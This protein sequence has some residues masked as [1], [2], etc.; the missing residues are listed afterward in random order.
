MRKLAPLT[1]TLILFL[2]GFAAAAPGDT[3]ATIATCLGRFSAEVEHATLLGQDRAEIAAGR[4][5]FLELYETV[6]SRALL[7]LRIRA[8]TEQARLLELAWFGTNARHADLALRKANA[9]I[10]TCTGLLLVQPEAGP[11]PQ[12]RMGL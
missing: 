1:V 7:A 3:G 2:N 8:K 6:G 4:E 5:V 12:E 9:Q 10:S 11:P